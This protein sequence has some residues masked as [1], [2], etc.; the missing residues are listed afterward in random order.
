LFYFGWL[1]VFTSKAVFIPEIYWDEQTLAR[2]A[3]NGF[4]LGSVANSQGSMAPNGD[5]PPPLDH[6]HPPSI[7]PFSQ[8]ETDDREE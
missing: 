6:H 5:V 4:R 8:K 7:K 2:L 3:M 1:I